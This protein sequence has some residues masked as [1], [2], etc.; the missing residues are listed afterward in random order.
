MYHQHRELAEARE[1]MVRRLQEL[2]D[3][4]EGMFRQ[5]QEQQYHVLQH[6]EQQLQSR[7]L[8]SSR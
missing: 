5:H 6:Q 2:A 1:G 7:Y 8:S 3:A 4:R